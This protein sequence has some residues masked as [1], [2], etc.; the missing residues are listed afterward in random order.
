MAEESTTL[1]VPFQR[2]STVPPFLIDWV[3]GVK[4]LLLT[5]TTAGPL[6][7]HAEEARGSATTA[8]RG[9]TL[10]T[11]RLLRSIWRC[12]F[13]RVRAPPFASARADHLLA[14]CAS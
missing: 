3:G 14:P 5:C 7:A 4:K 10:A 8:A 11:R 1:C 12:S 9:T 13:R 6:A 2:H